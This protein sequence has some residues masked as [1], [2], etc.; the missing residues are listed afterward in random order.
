MKD[1]IKDASPCLHCDDDYGLSWACKP[2]SRHDQA[3]DR[4]VQCHCG[5]RG[6]FSYDEGEAVAWW[7]DTCGTGYRACIQC[8][9]AFEWREQKEDYDHVGLT[10]H[11]LQCAKECDVEIPEEEEP[12]ERWGIV[13]DMIV[14]YGLDRVTDQYRTWIRNEEEK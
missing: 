9:E 3:D 8:Y 12:D 6:P 14:K 11:C 5:A 4:A 7:N 1:A 13:N 2:S 10:K